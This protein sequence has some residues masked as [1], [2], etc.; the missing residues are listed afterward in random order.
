[1]M[2]SILDPQAEIAEGYASIV[3][4]RRDGTTVAGL[5][6]AEEPDSIR[7]DLGDGEIETIR[8]ADIASRTAPTSGMP[9]MGL[10]LPALDLRDVIAYVMS[11]E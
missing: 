2:A 5:L 8:T 4:T 11:L 10:V 6:V 9:P 7:L 1:M 3:V